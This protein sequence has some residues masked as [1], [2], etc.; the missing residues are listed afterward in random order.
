MIEFR[1]SRDRHPG[2][3]SKQDVWSTFRPN[4]QPGVMPDAFGALRIVDEYR[5]RPGARVARRSR[6]DAEFVTYVRE[7]ALAYEDSTGRSG[8]LHAGEFQRVSVQHSIRHSEMNASRRDL[9]QVFQFG[10]RPSLAGLDLALE[11]KR[12]SVAQRRGELCVVASG[13]ARR[14]SLR[15]RQDALVFSAIL[16]AGQHVVHELA[17]GRS[18]WVHVV[19]G[20]VAFAGTTLSTGDGAGVTEERSISLTAREESE[21]LLLDLLQA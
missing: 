1:K 2:E 21:V 7:G 4:D 19:Q 18:G 6:E 14:G 12:F 20:R 15:L 16:Y 11:Q 13:D 3:R 8:V 5:L 10:L 9:A 17:A